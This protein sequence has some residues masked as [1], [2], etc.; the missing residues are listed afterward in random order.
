M[1]RSSFLRHRDVSHETLRRL[2][3]YE[4]LLRKWNPAI[5]LVS[6][7]TLNHVWT[8]H[9]LDS[10]Q[11][12]DL[13]PADAATW[14]DLGSGGGFPGLVAAIIALEEQPGLRFS[15][16]EADQRKCAFLSEAAR[17]LSLNADVVNARIEAIDPLSADIISARALAPL[18]AL[19]SFAER[20]LATGGV[21]IFPKGARCNEEISQALENWRFTYENH[22]SLTDTDGV[23][24]KVG[25]I[26]RV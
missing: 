18:G 25:E 11:V 19:L 16:V 2:E 20:H 15:L 5:N 26:V 21:A 3:H 24:L 14:A 13:R 1:T 8:R 23:I 4:A 6:T 9:F 22:P 7:P 12:F 17:T 10:A